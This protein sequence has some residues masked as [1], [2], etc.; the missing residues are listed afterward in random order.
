[1]FNEQAYQ[2][3]V[4]WQMWHLF[5]NVRRNYANHRIHAKAANLQTSKIVLDMKYIIETSVPKHILTAI[6]A[7]L[8]RAKAK[9]PQWP[10]DP[11][12]AASIVG[13]ESGELIRAAVIHVYENGSEAECW[14]EA[15]QTAATAIRF[16]EGIE[17]N[18]Y[19]PEKRY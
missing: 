7:E 2:K 13:E 14:K 3:N 11:I 17:S 5:R 19:Y 6:L 16:L 8:E 12:H 10:S 1:M 15:V 4:Y 9:F 18:R